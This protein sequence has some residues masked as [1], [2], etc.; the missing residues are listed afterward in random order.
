MSD[1]SKCIDVKCP[2]RDKCW[3]YTAPVSPHQSYSDFGRPEGAQE[4]ESFWQVVPD[5]NPKLKP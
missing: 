5:L 4:C 1:F 2:S 3:R